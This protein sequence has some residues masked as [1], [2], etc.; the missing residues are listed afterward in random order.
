MA[1][2]SE[3]LFPNKVAT[4]HRRIHLS[5]VYCS[6]CTM[7]NLRPRVC[8]YTRMCRSVIANKGKQQHNIIDMSL[9]QMNTVVMGVDLC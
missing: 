7:S 6:V 1:P 9:V 5:I 4:Q 2:I 3:C 8:F